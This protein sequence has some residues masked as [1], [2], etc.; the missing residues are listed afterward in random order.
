M[1]TSR[2]IVRWLVVVALVV[3][4][5]A[6]IVGLILFLAKQGRQAANEYAGPL[7]LLVA[8][9][10]A[11]CSLVMRGIRWARQKR[12]LPIDEVTRL[13]R[14]QIRR[15]EE[16][17]R[18]GLIGGG[19]T[20]R[21]SFF[22][23]RESSVTNNLLKRALTLMRFRD[24]R[25][26]AL[27]DLG[28]LDSYYLLQTAGRLVIVG[29][30]GSGKTVAA[31][32][33]VL[34]LLGPRSDD[35]H[36][37]IVPVRIS[38]ANWDTKRDLR[39][40]LA[41]EIVSNYRVSLLD[42]N[43]LMQSGRVL[44]ILDGLDEMDPEPKE[45]G[46]LP[47]RAVEAVRALN[48]YL[49]G[50]KGAPF[51]LTTRQSR[52]DQILS[53][54]V[55]VSAQVIYVESLTARQIS[56]YLDERYASSPRRHEWDNVITELYKADHSPELR[57]LSTP[58]KLLL[59]VTAFDSGEQPNR[60]FARNIFESPDDASLRIQT[61]LLAAYVPA[62][63]RLS[64]R[65]RSG[66]GDEHYN[67][68]AV[69]TWL[70]AI[71][72]HL[73]WQ[74]DQAALL[75]KVA[76]GLSGT[77]VVPHFL[78]PIA[79]DSLVRFLHVMVAAIIVGIP[80]LPALFVGVGPPSNWMPALNFMLSEL[81]FYDSSSAYLTA[82]ET[83]SGIALLVICGVILA[84]GADTWKRWPSV[85]PK[86]VR[87]RPDPGSGRSIALMTLAGF[88]IWTV[89]GG[90][91][92]IIASYHLDLRPSVSLGVLSFC[93]FFVVL[94]DAVLGEG[95]PVAPV[96]PYEVL[97]R[98]FS[99]GSALSG[100]G[101][102]VVG[103]LLGSDIAG[104]GGAMAFAALG[105]GGWVAASSILRM[106]Y[107]ITCV[108]GCLSGS[109]PLRTARFLEWASYSGILRV[110]GGSFQFRH[111]ELREWLRGSSLPDGDMAL[112]QNILDE[113]G[114]PEDER[115]WMAGRDEP[116]V[117]VQESIE[118]TLRSAVV[119]NGCRSMGI[120]VLALGESLKSQEHVFIQVGE[121]AHFS[122]TRLRENYF[123]AAR[124]ERRVLALSTACAIGVSLAGSISAL[125]LSALVVRAFGVS[126]WWSGTIAAGL[127]FVPYAKF[128][129]KLYK[130]DMDIAGSCIQSVVIGGLASIMFW[131]AQYGVTVGAVAFVVVLSLAL[132]IIWGSVLWLGIAIQRSA[133][134]EAAAIDAFEMWHDTIRREGLY[135]HIRRQIGVAPA[136]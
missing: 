23:R 32:E 75:R 26:K 66:R 87:Q 57:V 68:A 19:S 116:L 73:D 94:A 67:P 96:S 100:V 124:R 2:A 98:E 33:L 133:E 28:S 127:L 78:W 10:G 51:V 40:W 109:L 95:R 80:T 89:I 63:T 12:G 76:P 92:F 71:S 25:G 8:V 49:D 105:L 130:S 81:E 97:Q 29:E 13:L 53:C 36:E 3:A 17:V 38:I 21:W 60:I 117:V 121:R 18:D 90:T 93:P 131:R 43:E 61:E 42:S 135:P 86:R 70:R 62:A 119:E 74:E 44:P 6:G 34:R 56:K 5:A 72:R 125:I 120:P 122:Y 118:D 83:R 112:D 59:A 45:Q 11:G 30:P 85:R 47:E 103:G 7:A 101:S 41:D 134:S 113:A 126:W 77:D 24:V 136:Y 69:E 16:V 35:N 102:V 123:A 99:W 9:V 52:Y 65:W 22:E 58:W 54:D 84:I 4:L 15:V 115:P 37:R 79:G 110:A 55:A 114:G 107:A 50:A 106:R 108:L 91:V 1:R 104:V 82:E 88:V 111:A 132:G 27:G 14:G 64:P 46:E 128:L 31:S 48:S 39:T 20:A 129:S